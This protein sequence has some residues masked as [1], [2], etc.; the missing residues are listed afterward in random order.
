MVHA[1]DWRIRTER[2]TPIPAKTTVA[3]ENAYKMNVSVYISDKRISLGIPGRLCQLSG[4]SL[5]ERLWSDRAI[6]SIDRRH[7]GTDLVLGLAVEEQQESRWKIRSF[8]ARWQ[9][10]V[11]EDR[12]WYA[13]YKLSKYRLL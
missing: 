5:E 6:L 13:C 10:D 4:R 3:G 1:K 9:V 12:S 8:E 7:S 11:E 2:R